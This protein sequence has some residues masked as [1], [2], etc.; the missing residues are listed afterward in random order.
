MWRVNIGYIHKKIKLPSLEEA[1]KE[2]IRLEPEPDHFIYVLRIEPSTIRTDIKRGRVYYSTFLPVKDDEYIEVRDHKPLTPNGESLADFYLRVTSGSKKD[3]W[4]I[5]QIHKDKIQFLYKYVGGIYA[6]EYIHF[7]W[8][9][10]Q[11]YIGDYNADI[12][13]SLK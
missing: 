11:H 6:T 13:K 3:R 12:N 9:T 2:A 7:Q 10:K 1:L 8:R 5:M 4:C